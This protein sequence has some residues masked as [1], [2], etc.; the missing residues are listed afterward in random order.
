MHLHCTSDIY[1]KN[2]T[3]TTYILRKCVN[4]NDNEKPILLW[5][6]LQRSGW[7]PVTL[8]GA[9][10]PTV[11]CCRPFDR[12]PAT[13]HSCC[14]GSAPPPRCKHQ[15]LDRCPALLALSAGLHPPSSLPSLA[16]IHLH[17]KG[18]VSHRV[19]HLGVNMACLTSLRLSQIVQREQYTF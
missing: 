15:Q 6:P 16:W 17:T 5:H 7:W 18:P 19:W 11:W 9:F 14:S 4:Y 1:G 3:K 8:L 2:T 13:G 12:W 10:W